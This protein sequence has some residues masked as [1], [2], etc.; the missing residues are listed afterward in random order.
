[1]IRAALALV[2]VAVVLS[3]APALAQDDGGSRFELEARLW[4]AAPGGEV[5]VIADELGTT[6]D[7]E[8]DLGLGDDEAF[9]GR[10]TLRPSR[11]TKVY[12][13]WTQLEFAG[14]EVLTR[15]IEFG[16]E[17]F[18]LS[19]RI[20]SLVDFDYGRAG[21]AWQFLASDDGRLRFGPLVEVK[22]FRGEA[23]LAAPDVP[24]LP[25]VTEEFE[26]AVGAAGAAL[27]FEPSERFQVFAEGSVVVGQD[28]GDATD[29][30]AGLRFLA[31][32]RLAV[33]G[34]YRTFSVDAQ[35]DD[36]VLDIDFDGAFAGVQLRF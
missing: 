15:T 19:T 30:E 8:S 33:L 29:L 13:A 28:E 6:I 34:G 5:L 4:A 24:L 26:A 17:T 7:L 10:L 23:S 16:G 9:E 25:A 18:T 14:D 21:F 12:F 3:A 31:T 2:L 11:R 36:D 27:D 22:G 20:A 35:E 1:M 32:S